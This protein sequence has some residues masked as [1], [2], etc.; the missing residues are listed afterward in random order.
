MHA[1]ANDRPAI[2]KIPHQLL[3]LY[4]L[5][6]LILYLL[7][8]YRGFS[9]SYVVAAKESAGKRQLLSALNVT[10][11]S[12]YVNYIANFELLNFQFRFVDYSHIRLQYQFMIFLQIGLNFDI[13]CKCVLQIH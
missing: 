12:R 6:G 8:N 7:I 5:K 9:I 13:G 2:R 4:N 11:S 10:F 3:L 1:E